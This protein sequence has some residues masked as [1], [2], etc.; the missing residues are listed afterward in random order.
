M[1]KIFLSIVTTLVCVVLQAQSQDENYV[2]T[3]TYTVPSDEEPTATGTKKIIGVEYYDGLGRP[4]QQVGVQ[5]APNGDDFVIPIVYD[6]AGRV[7]RGYLPYYQSNNGLYR[8]NNEVIEELDSIYLLKFPTDL[9]PLHPNP[10]TETVFEESLLNRT[11]A[12]AAPGKDWSLEDGTHL[13]EVIYDKNSALEV[14]K[15]SVGYIGGSMGTI[16]LVYEDYY[17]EGELYK[18]ISKDENWDVSSG[19]SHTVEEFKDKSGN[20]I[21]KRTYTREGISDIAHDT[22]Y[23]YDDFG[24][25]TYVL[26][27]EASD[28]I[29]DTSNN[30]VNQIIDDLGYQYKYDYRNRLI[31]KK[32]PGKG[33][34]YIV[35][36][37]LDRVMMTQDQNLK[38]Q[39]KWL[40]TKYDVLNRPV[41]T[42]LYSSGIAR[43]YMQMFVNAA[44]EVN[45]TRLTSPIAYTDVQ[46]FYS[47]DVFPNDVNALTILTV[48]YYD[49]YNFDSPLTMEA[50]SAV[51][52]LNRVIVDGNKIRK[53][54]NSVHWN[55][56]FQTQE[57]ITG[58]GYLEYT[59]LHLDKRQ[60]I[61]LSTSVNLDTNYSYTTI[62]YSIDT[63]YDNLVRIRENGVGVST[64]VSYVAGDRFR[65]ERLGDQIYYKKNGVTFYQSQH[66]TSETL[67]GDASFLHYLSEIEDLTVVN[68]AYGA[69]FTEKTKGLVT[70]N[71]T[72]VLDTSNFIRTVTHYDKKARPIYMV[73]QN[74]YLNTV[75]VVKTDLDF[76]GNIMETTTIHTKG[77]NAPIVTIDQFVYDHQFRLLT[78]TQ[79]I[80]NNP[81]EVIVL[82]AYNEFG[83][84]VQKKTGAIVD[85]ISTNITNIHRVAQDGNV[86]S[87]V[88]I[89]GWDGNFETEE[90][91]TGDGYI[92]F[93]VTEIGKYNM[94]GL[95][96][97]TE[98][99]D[100]SYTSIDYAI[101]T[102]SSTGNGD[103]VLV[104]E[105]GVN[106]PIPVT[107]FVAGDVFRVER[108]GSTIEYKK[109][110]TTFYTSQ[111][112]FTG[113]LV[114][115]ASLGALGS[116]IKDLKLV[117]KNSNAGQALQTIDYAYNIRGWLKQINDPAQS[118]T[119]DIFAFKINYNTTDT[120]LGAEALYNG[121]ISETIWKVIVDDEQ[122]AYGYNYDELN[123]IK[124]ANFGA[125]VNQTNQQGFY[126]LNSIAYDK[127]GNILNLSR[128]AGNVGHTAAT[129]MDNLSYTYLPNTNQLAS[130]TDSSNNIEGFKD[131]YINSSDPADVDYVYDANGN[132]ISDKNKQITSITYNHLNLPKRV[133]FMNPTGGSDNTIDYVYD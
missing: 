125:G 1:R 49:D 103:R 16:S 37:K 73:S 45:E 47:N 62:D 19:K 89:A 17:P 90:K 12:Q 95:S 119:D 76:T 68:S 50:S 104:R 6:Q 35:Y 115:D 110:G 44:T 124:S 27:P 61:G 20:M 67:Y 29:L 100:Y 94:I 72:R 57:G 83:Q 88:A 5:A 130:V 108:T 101:Y 10:Y 85:E 21:L 26:S 78:Q 86:I 56:G 24:N 93:T 113:D 87:K 77:T 65:I 131:G 32:I 2:K 69:S 121:N 71:M 118:L 22:Q 53:D 98:L 30:V 133:S 13:V 38:F 54:I 60:M 84:L 96:D 52:N 132:M 79:Q 102:G 74:D 51:T 46:L 63:G 15:F 105:E 9:D 34:E 25:L 114:G 75:D 14:R 8:N 109:N 80:D 4:K 112:T 99:L 31:E 107:Y 106:I 42:G 92:E 70:G 28:N 3:T 120:T 66:S 97:P 41:Y 40:L 43:Q 81:K 127:N 129:T 126:N 18:T 59:V 116:Y 122:R 58:D 39:G 33:W 117:N 82:N 111:T 23:V 7:S 48:N 123:R 55:G 11:L 128:N 91:L 36:D 64:N